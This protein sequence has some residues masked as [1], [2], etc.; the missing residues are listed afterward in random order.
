MLIF[1]ATVVM[2]C[3]TRRKVQPPGVGGDSDE[4]AEERPCVWE[5]YEDP[6]TFTRFTQTRRHTYTN[7]PSHTD[8]HSDT[9]TH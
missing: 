4:Q 1:R 7:A 3:G 6:G 2:L 9:H 5:E 8:V